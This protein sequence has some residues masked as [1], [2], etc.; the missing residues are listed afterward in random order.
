MKY[1]GYVCLGL[2]VLVLL[3]SLA[4][5]LEWAGIKWKGFFGPKHAAVERQVFEQTR[6]YNAG[7][8]QELTKLKFEYDRAETEQEKKAVLSMVRHAFAEY[9]E[10]LINSPDLR[11][12]LQKVKTGQI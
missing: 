3:G 1:V 6:S 9:D 5:G 10:K 2:V 8:A 12:W 4:F 7:K 11:E